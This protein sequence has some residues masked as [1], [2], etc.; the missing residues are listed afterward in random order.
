M[1]RREREREKGVHALQKK[2]VFKMHVS[3]YI[4]KAER[5]VKR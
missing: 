4:K 1:D 3:R 2:K 5:T